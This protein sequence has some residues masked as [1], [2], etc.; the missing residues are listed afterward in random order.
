MRKKYY[1][2][3]YNFGGFLKKVA[4][5]GLGILGAGIGSLIAPGAGTMLGA[6]LGA[7]IGGQ[8]GGILAADEQQKEAAA[9]Q[10][11]MT[12]QQRQQQLI[13]S[14]LATIKPSTQYNQSYANG[15]M[16]DSYGKGGIYIN[17]AKR[18]TF[19]AQA[20]KMGM[21]VQEAASK[22]LN[23][24]EGKYSPAMR[25][26]ANFAKNFAHGNGGPL[27]DT[28][29]WHAA[30]S[31][32][33]NKNPEMVNQSM[34]NYYADK[35]IPK[36][37]SA[38][39][40]NFT[41]NMPQSFGD[42]MKYADEFAKT[43]PSFNIPLNKLNEYGVDSANFAN[44][45]AYLER[46]RGADTSGK[47]STVP[48]AFGA[49]SIAMMTPAQMYK[50][51]VV[52][53]NPS[54]VVRTSKYSAEYNPITGVKSTPLELMKGAYYPSSIPTKKSHGGMIDN[55]VVSSSNLD[56]VTQYSTGGTHEENSLGGIPIGRKSSVEQGEVRYKDYI[57]SNRLKRG[58]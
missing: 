29:Y 31:A 10:Q 56:G 35:L 30:D 48:Q 5:V 17:P 9:Q 54:K 16:I 38:L 1:N 43:N 50:E 19:K 57:F 42:K 39:M 7:S 58:K 11:L 27:N 20:T 23:A 6:S 55:N 37:D 21:S 51:T 22:I 40:S 18:G 41:K 52:N 46:L 4:P 34:Y 45:R 12:D 3:Q 33:V 44:S 32:M 47:G 24:P 26:K 28:D 49:R 53:N 15:G 8:A 14:K 36:M 2:E 13:A 25:K